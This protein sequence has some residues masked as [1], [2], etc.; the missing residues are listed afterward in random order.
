[1]LSPTGLEAPN[2]VSILVVD[3]DADAFLP[4]LR[5]RFEVTAVTSEAQAVRALKAFQPTMV[6]T[7][8]ALP[9]GD[10]VS[11]CRQSKMGEAGVTLALATTSEPE[12]VPAA[13]KAGCD[14]VLMKP[15][16]PNL[17]YTRVGR[18]LRIREKELNDRAM[19]QHARSTF[20]IEHAPHVT[21]GTNVVCHDA[22]CPSCGRGGGVGFDAASHR[23]MWY[24][25]LPCGNVWMAPHHDGLKSRS[26][27]AV[28]LDDQRLRA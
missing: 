28:P 6:I 9:D 3:P 19:W 7:E 14:G 1:M 4:V 27:A 10:G 26:P 23:R 16:A 13:L 21:A 17:L 24:A 25:C 12:R 20:R 11:I 15:F 2:P 18:L 5:R 8:L 22:V